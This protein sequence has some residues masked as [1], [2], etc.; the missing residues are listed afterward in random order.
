MHHASTRTKQSIHF[1]FIIEGGSVLDGSGADAIT[2]DVGVIGDRIVAVDNL[3]GADALCRID[4]RGLTLA[5]GF[6]DCHSHDDCAVLD[7]PEMLPKISQGVTTVVNGNCGLS[8][9]PLATDHVAK[10]SKPLPAP[11][12]LFSEN[13]FSYKTMA[14]YRGAIDTATASVNVAQLIGHGTLRATFV[15]D[16]TRP[17]NEH[18]LTQMCAA[19]EEAMDAGCLG[20]SAGLAYRSS[21]AA[22]TAE[23]CG[24]PVRRARVFQNRYEIARP[25]KPA[26][27]CRGS[28]NCGDRR[29]A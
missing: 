15:D 10:L 8:L 5:P 26:A 13:A 1:D 27:S 11:L 12:S 4:A 20:L 7:T 24:A 18:E 25:I 14:A 16:I 19:I 28:S 21:S 23:R 9:A 22:T 6:I 2:A 17:A 3:A 29:R